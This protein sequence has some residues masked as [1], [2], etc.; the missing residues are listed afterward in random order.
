[1][2]SRPDPVRRD[3][4]AAYTGIPPWDIGRPQPV[5][6]ELVQ[7]GKLRGSVL[8]VG[9]GT[10]EHALYLA[11]HGHE[12]WGVD[13]SPTAIGKA[14]QKAT[15]RGVAVTFRVVDALQLQALGR[16]FETIIDS[17]LFHIFSDEERVL[18]VQSLTS[19]LNVGGT[20]YLLCFSNQESGFSSGPRRVSQAE[21]SA[22]FS[23]G[24]RV[25]QIRATRFETTFGSAAAAWLAE[26]RRV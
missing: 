23:Q 20:Y 5:Y 1:M 10:G 25:E 11:Q 8:D 15:A 19:V 21:I 3:F 13:S 26:I 14:Q 24:W 9:C 17:G 22:T 12:V 2:N 7:T 18:F 4:E 16:T 6:V